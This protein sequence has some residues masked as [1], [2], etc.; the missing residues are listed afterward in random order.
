MN[1]NHYNIA[2]IGNAISWCSDC[3]AIKILDQ[4][5]VIPKK[6]SSKTS[7]LHDINEVCKKHGS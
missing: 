5:W 2:A 6:D 7:L 3:G 4:K 1:C